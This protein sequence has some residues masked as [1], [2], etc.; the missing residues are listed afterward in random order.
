[1]FGR[2]T[3][4]RSTSSNSAIDGSIH[5]NDNDNGNYNAVNHA[6]DTGSSSSS[7]SSS[8]MKL[9]KEA[10]VTG[11]DGSKHPFEIIW[12]CS[13]V[14]W[15]CWLY[16][17]VTVLLL[18]LTTNTIPNT[19][20]SLSSSSSSSSPSSQQQRQQQQR[21]TTIVFFLLEAFLIW[22]P[23]VLAQTNYLYPY[24]TLVMISQLSVAAI[25]AMVRTTRRNRRRKKKE[26]ML[27]KA[28]T[29]SVMMKHP[30]EDGEEAIAATASIFTPKKAEEVATTTT[31][32]MSVAGVDVDVEV[33][34][35]DRN[36]CDRN[37][38]D[39]DNN[40]GDPTTND[41]TNTMVDGSSESD[42]N[43]ES[44]SE[45]EFKII[46]NPENGHLHSIRNPSYGNLQGLQHCHKKSTLDND[47]SND[48]HKNKNKNNNNNEEEEEEEV[49]QD[50]DEEEEFEIIRGPN[51]RLETVKKERRIRTTVKQRH[52]YPHSALEKETTT[53]TTTATPEPH[54]DHVVES[55]TS[56][57]TTTT[58]AHNAIANDTI[59][60]S[61][62]NSMRTTTTNSATTTA[63]T[64][65]EYLTLYRSS[66]YYLTFIA[67]L[68]VDFPLFPRR[69]CKTEISGYG[70]MDVGAA[71]FVI[72]SGIVS[73][74]SY[75]TLAATTMASTTTTTTSLSS[76]SAA[77]AGSW[78][79]VFK[80]LRNALP[81]LVIGIIRCYTNKNL[82]Y[83]EHVT[84]YGIQWNFFFTLGVLT[85]LPPLRKQ[86]IWKLST[87]HS[88]NYFKKDLILLLYGLPFI[89]MILY[90]M[91]LSNYGLQEFIET[92][93]RRV[94]VSS[95]VTDRQHGYL[96]P[97]YV[98]NREGIVGCIGYL[99]L[100][101]CSEVIGH[102]C[103]FTEDTT[104][105]RKNKTAVSSSSSSSFSLGSVAVVLWMVHFGI[106]YLFHFRISRRSTNLSFCLWSL[107][108]NITI[109]GSLQ[110]LV[111][112]VSSVA[113]LPSSSSSSSCTT[114]TPCC[115]DDDAKE[116]GGGREGEGREGEDT[117][118]AKL[119]VST[120]TR[121]VRSS[122]RTVSSSSSSSSSSLLVVVPHCM[123]LIN[124]H[125]MLSFLL[126]NL[127]T[128][129]VNITLPT[130]DIPDR[131]AV[132]IVFGYICV[133]SVVLLLLDQV[134]V[135]LL[136]FVSTMQRKRKN[137]QQ[138]RKRRRSQKK[139]S[140][141]Y[142]NHNH[143]TATTTTT[144]TTTTI[145]KE[146]EKIE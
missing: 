58:T 97:F 24:G 134:W 64:N 113:T 18:D 51:G 63:P 136:L 135:P 25:F 11:H 140:T 16:L 40:D 43:S 114:T 82:D 84:E 122:F 94:V 56:N 132:G 21:I 1:M 127:L 71:S 76:S 99:F 144:P 38:S 107:A 109:V 77:G 22:F 93:P 48:N 60:H 67:I 17:E 120:T 91:L 3:N 68:A 106:E 90:Q 89:G 117:T 129:L 46:R 59:N 146:K 78:S 80:P 4:R 98:G 75:A 86:L 70:L 12:V 69:F 133:V 72:S 119:A 141:T 101:A 118:D 34:V 108:H 137:S 15:G 55:I 62:S 115:I 44:D 103:I 7:N 29:E 143:A 37:K 66:I 128:G 19:T 26:V 41:K 49:E 124:K 6:T 47:N 92:A 36:S 96:Y 112:C 145:E 32:T 9:R 30:V 83:Q 8:I 85:I 14:V 61:N 20:T 13:S 100:H 125:G 102:Y 27:R 57:T 95:S 130:I 73:G 31:V 5:D 126:A 88:T 138:H 121:T 52:P 2:M 10:F 39:N 42:N 81:L 105:K 23:M 110:Q 104:K 53:A 50:T 45:S 111:A 28:D 116:E 131:V 142:Q 74:K 139:K 65:I 87:S 79:T 33:D 54:A 123:H 35:D